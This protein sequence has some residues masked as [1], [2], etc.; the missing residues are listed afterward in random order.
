MLGAHGLPLAELGSVIGNSM[1]L[2][3][4]KSM[5]KRGVCLECS[6]GNQ[7][8]ILENKQLFMTRGI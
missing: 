7:F 1:N 5:G 8:F 3:V 6:H 4:K 2:L